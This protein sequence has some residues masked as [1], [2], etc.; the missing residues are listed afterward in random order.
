VTLNS[1]QVNV[2]VVASEALAL[3]IESVTGAI[4]FSKSKSFTNGT[5]AGKAQVVFS[6]IGSLAGSASVSLDLAGALLDAFGKTITFTKIKAI[7]VYADPANNAANPVVVS[8]PTANGLPLLGT[9]N[10][11]V[12]GLE[13]GGL[14]LYMSPGANG[15]AVT[16]GTADILTITNGA[17]TNTVSY[18]IIIIGEGTVA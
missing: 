5:G 8:R 9:A 17:G 13:P 10:V 6:D 18:Q 3:D 15:I 7:L 1:A 4:N 2:Q 11:T 12:A 14:F 16:A